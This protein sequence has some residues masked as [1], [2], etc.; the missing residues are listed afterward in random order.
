M[1][2]LALARP[3]IEQEIQTRLQELFRHL[4]G[5]V[6]ARKISSGP[7]EGGPLPAGLLARRILLVHWAGF[8]GVGSP[9]RPRQCCRG[10]AACKLHQ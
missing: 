7:L 5:S 4:A 9:A 10:L 3:E 1:H 6:V 2:F 8:L